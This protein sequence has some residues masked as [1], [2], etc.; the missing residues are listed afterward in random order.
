MIPR[1]K[2][3]MSNY[4]KVVLYVTLV[5]NVCRCSGRPCRKPEDLGRPKAKFGASSGEIV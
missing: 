4:Q 2:M 1:D 5:A 3:K